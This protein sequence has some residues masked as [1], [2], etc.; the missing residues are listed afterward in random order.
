MRLLIDKGANVNAADM[1]DG[2]TPLIVIMR[3]QSSGYIDIAKL[4]IDKGADLNA[5]ARDG[6]TA[7]HDAAAKGNNV[8]VEFLLDHGADPR[9]QGLNGRTPYLVALSRGHRDT[10]ALIEKRT[11][12]KK[13]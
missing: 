8:E 3:H 7:L 13:R 9:I 6:Y 2:A 5:Q 11:T 12:R 10:A 1:N 4:L